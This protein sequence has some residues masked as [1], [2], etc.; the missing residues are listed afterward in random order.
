MTGATSKPQPVWKLF[1][2]SEAL[3]TSLAQTILDEAERAIA[4]HGEFRIVLAGG[5]TPQRV[6]A[7]L[8][9][10]QTDWRNWHIW[11]GDERCYPPG[12]PERNDSM[13]DE[14]LLRHID[15]PR[16]NV[17]R[18]L[19]DNQST[20]VADYL[21]CLPQGLFDLV[22]L[23]MGEDGHTASLFPGKDWGETES[24]PAV[25]AVHHSPKPPPD[26]V[27]LS[28]WRLGQSR[29][30]IFVVT[31]TSKAAAIR[32]WRSGEKLPVS[33]IAAPRIEVW[34]D[35]TAMEKTRQPINS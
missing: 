17:H 2:D 35:R 29:K 5:S 7:K 16:E 12:H 24:S 6:Y 4:R 9:G 25:L 33:A 1:I 3:A 22:L 23:G 18:V 34:L 32:G 14:A 19:A 27:S 21:A 8:V 20:A 31:G 28:A 10:A 15:I 11:F 26:R 30:V 13:A